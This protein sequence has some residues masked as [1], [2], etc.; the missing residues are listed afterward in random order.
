MGCKNA[1]LGSRSSENNQGDREASEIIN[2]KSETF[3]VQAEI[4]D[5]KPVV[6][7]TICLYLDLTPEIDPKPIQSAFRGHLCRKQIAPELQNFRDKKF[8]NVGALY[9]KVSEDF[10]ALEPPGLS[11]L[12]CHLPELCLHKPEDGHFCAAPVS[13]APGQRCGV[14]R[15]VGQGGQDAWDRQNAFPRWL[16]TAGLLQR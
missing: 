5:D 3:E 14:R 8:L 1:C 9:E 12:E 11:S 16:Q 2:K 13:F 15:R 4:G 10:E 7:E 6:V